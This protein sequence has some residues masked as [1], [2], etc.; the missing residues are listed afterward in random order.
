MG[1]SHDILNARYLVE[2]RWR[3]VRRYEVGSFDLGVPV[4]FA[5]SQLRPATAA[6][7]DG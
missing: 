3:G 1:Q 4:E 7:N 5:Q 2:Y 6:R